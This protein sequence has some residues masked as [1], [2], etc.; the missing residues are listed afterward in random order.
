VVIEKQ[1]ADEACP[2]LEG[3]VIWL[4]RGDVRQATQNCWRCNMATRIRKVKAQKPVYSDDQVRQIM[5]EYFFQRN[6]N[7][8]SRRGKKSGAAV[9]I[10]VMRADLKSAHG[11][12]IQQVQSNLTYLLSQG[13]VEDEPVIKT[14]P[15]ARGAQIPSATHYYVI[16]AAG[17]DKISGPS[18]FTRNRFEGIRIEA[19]GQNIITLGD[20]NQV[21]A[22]YRQIGE[23]LSELR[24][25]VKASSELEEENKIELVSDIDSLQDQLAKPTPNRSVVRT[26]WEAISRSASLATLAES[27][28]KVAPYVAKLIN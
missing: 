28:A 1:G 10:S 16:T 13:W 11:L 24:A 18:E 6:K 3:L 19:T 12:T 27:A 2:A 14:I 21:N 26:L 17:I 22:E 7:A 4:A 5:L 9:P 8:T 15:T 25:A 23:G 20:G